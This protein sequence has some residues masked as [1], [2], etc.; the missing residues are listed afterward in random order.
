MGVQPGYRLDRLSG[1]YLLLEDER[2]RERSLYPLYEANFGFDLWRLLHA[3]GRR[4]W[5]EANYGAATYMPLRDGARF[6]VQLSNLG[7]MARPLNTEALEALE[8]WE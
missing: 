7:V 4:D 3:S 6:S 1:R 8:S 5:V 2:E